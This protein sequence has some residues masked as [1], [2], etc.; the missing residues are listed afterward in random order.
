MDIKNEI[1]NGVKIASDAATDA[2][3]ALVEKSR[4]RANANR[5][6]QVIKSDSELRNQAYIEL[7]R[8][9]YENMRDSM[10]PS[11]EE[12]CVII[13]KTSKRIEK[14]TNKYIEFV[15]LANDIRLGNENTDRIKKAVSDK[16]SAAKEKASIISNTKTTD[17]SVKDSK[18]EAVVDIE[19]K[20]KEDIE[21]IEVVFQPQED[22]EEI[23]YEE[24]IDSDEIVHECEVVETED[25]ESPE[26]FDF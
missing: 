2:V 20:A 24:E 3:Q 13:D 10:D 25:E 23:L 7:G 9:F 19:Y 26:D 21:D 12:L 1:K 15:A 4:L 22:I 11:Q 18:K 16:L 8:Y 6:R 17:V 5:I 14:A